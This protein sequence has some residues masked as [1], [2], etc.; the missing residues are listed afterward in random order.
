M[1]N[2]RCECLPLLGFFV[3]AFL[4]LMAPGDAGA[5]PVGTYSS[6]LN[7]GGQTFWGDGAVYG[8][9]YLQAPPA[10]PA[11][12]K[13]LECHQSGGGA[14]DKTSYLR[15]GHGNMVKKVSASQV[16]RGATAQPHSATNPF[17]HLIDWS[18]GS[19]RVNLGG[20][21]DVGGFEGQFSQEDC[22]AA[23]ACTLAKDDFISPAYTKT[24]CEAAGGTW[25]KGVWTPAERWADIIYFV[26]DW[27][28]SAAGYVDTGIKIAERPNKFMM[29]DGRQYGTCGSCHNTGYKASTYDRV[30]PYA[31]YPNFAG[32][33][34]SGALGSWVL[35]GIQC[36]RCHDASTHPNNGTPATVPDNTNSTF[37]CSQ[38]HIRPAAWEL[39]GTANP[40]AATA[41][42]A[43]P[44]GASATNF[45]SHLIGKQFLNSSHGRFTGAISEIATGLAK[46]S[47]TF[48][49]AEGTQGGCD[50]CHDV[51]ESTVAPA[52]TNFGA[53]GIRRG[54]DTCHAEEAGTVTTIH[55]TGSGTPSGAS[56]EASGACVKC[57]MPKPG[58]DGLNV[59]VFRINTDPDYST[60]PKQVGG[61]WTPGYCSDPAY[62]TR[63]TCVAAG[64]SWAGVAKS[65]PDGAYTNAVWV[66]LDLACGQCHGE[67]GSAHLMTKG[68]TATYAAGMHT[69]SSIPS[70]CSG[71][72]SDTA[73]VHPTGANMPTQCSDCHG[74]TRAGVKPTA[75]AGC[76]TCHS[77]TGVATHQF[78]EAQIKTYAEAIHAGGSTPSTTCTVCHTETPEEL[79]NHPNKTCTNCHS[80]AKPGVKPTYAQA[81]NSCHGEGSFMSQSYLATAAA[82]MHKNVAP[83]ASIWIDPAIDIDPVLEG[84]QVKLGD[85]FEVID[86]SSDLNRNIHSI[87]LKWGDGETAYLTPGEAVTHSYGKAGKK[88]ITVTAMDSKGLKSKKV[89][90][91]ITII[92]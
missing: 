40:A 7:A 41:P 20:Y 25:K 67:E 81:C 59:H 79:I 26:G 56:E 4:I 50:T 62:T 9:G 70:T 82:S 22:E 39:P 90:Q 80:T 71:C 65:A 86:T 43:Y 24:T 55:P 19:G 72:H 51:H 8:S 11:G 35:N 29:A 87:M 64:K 92:K 84:I 89:K 42:T 48:G 32:N 38:C 1:M 77:S 3:L 28:G 2:R 73:A 52:K 14:P 61:V 63:D 34:S 57:H 23:T 15:T 36:E 66:D 54:C 13:C 60:F 69:R 10:N 18:T 12:E 75:E 27:M 30:Q 74:T 6:E 5:A 85:T 68:I 16:W 58:G 44:I 45:G 76:L 53:E 83:Q 49:P 88:T 37:I 33:S 21:C 46:Y 91:K 78:T 17:G 31:D 47:S